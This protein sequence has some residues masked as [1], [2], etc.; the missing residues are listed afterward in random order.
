M[1]ALL[2]GQVI[3]YA[4]AAAQVAVVVLAILAV[5]DRR[6]GTRDAL[7]SWLHRHGLTLAFLVSF[8]A[9]TGSVI[10]SNVIGYP[11]CDLCWY[12]RIFLFPNMFMLGFAAWWKDRAVIRY[13]LM[14]AI[15]GGLVA[16]DHVWLQ[17]GGTSLIPCQAPTPTDPG[18]DQ[19]FV[20]ELGYVTIPVMSLTAFAL[21]TIF[22]VHAQDLIKGRRRK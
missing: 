7:T 1:D 6:S 5:R 11:P 2:F 19:R 15:I 13:A 20:F 12:Q 16:V 9:A 22:L 8:G 3:G 10:F 17:A 4:T 14:L 21:I 18:C